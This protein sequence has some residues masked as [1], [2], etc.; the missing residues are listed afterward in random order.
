MLKPF[1]IRDLYASPSAGHK[2]T[3][4]PPASRG[5]VQ[6]S[7]ADYDDIASNHPRAMLTYMDSDDGDQITVSARHEYSLYLLSGG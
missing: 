4:D 3:S 6:I 1:Q 2:V 5:V 7:A